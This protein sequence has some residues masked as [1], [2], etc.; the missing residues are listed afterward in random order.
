MT[1]AQRNYLKDTITGYAGIVKQHL[2]DGYQGYSMTFMFNPLTGGIRRMNQQMR[3]G[4]ENMYASLVTRLYRRPDAYGVIPP[5]LISCPDFPVAKYEKKS[6][7]EVTTNDGLHHHGILLIAPIPSRLKV[8]VPQ[9]FSDNQS[10]YV[11]D[12]VLN[13]IHIQPITHDV[14][15]IT[16]YTLKGLKTNRIQ[17]DEAILVLPHP[18]RASARPYQPDA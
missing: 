8:S 12:Q 15:G 16:D 4:I 2:D 18:Y 13:R 9:H 5:T 1:T 6:L 11:R 14:Y 10:L 7:L 17:D 3:N